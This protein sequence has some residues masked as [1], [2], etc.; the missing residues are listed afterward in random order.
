LLRVCFNPA[1][2]DNTDASHPRDLH[3]TSSIYRMPPD[4]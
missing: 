1:L 3:D 4:N 2:P